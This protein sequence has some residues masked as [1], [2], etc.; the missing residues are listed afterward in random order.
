LTAQGVVNYEEIP[1]YESDAGSDN[2]IEVIK[3]RRRKMKK[4]WNFYYKNV[5]KGGNANEIFQRDQILQ[6]S[7][8]LL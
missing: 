1:K 3:L 4:M 6:M 8:E 2:E 7:K 5:D